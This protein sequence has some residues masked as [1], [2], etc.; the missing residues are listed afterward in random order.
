MPGT[1]RKFSVS[2]VTPDGAAFEGDPFDALPEQ[3]PRAP[4]PLVELR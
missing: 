1:G 2:L 4:L 3:Y